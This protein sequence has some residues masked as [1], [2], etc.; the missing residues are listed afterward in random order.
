[1]AKRYTLLPVPKNEKEL[2]NAYEKHLSTFWTVNE[3]IFDDDKEEFD[4]LNSQ[5]KRMV[6]NN[7]SIFRQF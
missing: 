3:V 6:K 5:C 4:S 2:F 7:A 1:M